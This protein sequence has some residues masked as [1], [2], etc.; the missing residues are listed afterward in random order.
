MSLLLCRQENVT[1]PYYAENL[2]IH[3]YS[4]QELSYVIYHYPL[5]VLDG[6]VNDSLLEF[7]REELNQGFLAVKLERWLKS[8]ENPD[9]ALMLILQECDYCS[10]QEIS[11][12]RQEISEIRKKHPAEYGKLKASELFSMGQYGRTVKQYKKLLELPADEVVDDA[13]AGT[14]WNNIG[15]CYGRMFQPARALEAFEQSYTKMPDQ[16]VLR[17][18]YW[19]VKLDAKLVLGDR[20]KT[21]I[22]EELAGQWDSELQ[23]ARK[24]AVESGRL[25]NLE[26]LFERDPIKR[27]AGEIQL[28]K[29]WKKEYRAMV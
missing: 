19:L 22:T 15:V 28:I 24:G 1:R 3:I 5:L 17:Q 14:V 26:E 10:S 2:G 18:I 9:E 25:K 13:F 8:T 16:R 4:S 11:R 23:Q 20:F 6:F 7:L 29:K 27:Q 12:Y 21:L